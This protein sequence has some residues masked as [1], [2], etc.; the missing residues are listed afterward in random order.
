[1]AQRLL[2][3]ASVDGSESAHGTTHGGVAGGITPATAVVGVTTTMAVIPP[4]RA[5]VLALAPV[6]AP[7]P[8]LGRRIGTGGRG[9]HG[10]Q[11]VMDGAVAGIGTA[12]AGGGGAT[13]T[14]MGQL[15]RVRRHR[16]RSL[17]LLSV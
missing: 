10:R 16:L 8:V 14:R 2:A 3:V 7:A 5:P 6:R 1:M 9:G 17:A 13:A 15:H 11:T 4:R 12:T